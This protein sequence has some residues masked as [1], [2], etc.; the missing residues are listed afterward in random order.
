[1]R[2][3]PGLPSGVTAGPISRAKGDYSCCAISSCGWPACRS[4]SSFCCTCSAFC[5]EPGSG[6]NGAA[7]ECDRRWHGAA[8]HSCHLYTCCT[9]PGSGRIT[10]LRTT[11]AA[12]F[13]HRANS[14]CCRRWP[15]PTALVRRQSCRQPALIGR[16][17]PS[18]CAVSSPADCCSGDEP[19]EDARVYAVRLAPQGRKNAGDRRARASR[20]RER[21]A[22]FLDPKSTT[23]CVHR[24]PRFDHQR[25]MMGSAMPA[26]ASGWTQP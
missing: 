3:R 6:E 2:C 7:R 12:T 14:P 24:R 9:G 26:I 22:A 23:C 20:A 17:L 11:W 5:I 16:A 15:T 21:S 10:C 25:R 19:T 1:M 8:K 4:L 18:W 13:S